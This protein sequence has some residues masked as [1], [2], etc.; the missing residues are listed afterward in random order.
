MA[1][2]C[3]AIGIQNPKIGVA[4][5]NPHCGEN[6]MFGK[7]EIE[8]EYALGHDTLLQQYHTIH[9]MLLKKLYLV[10]LAFFLEY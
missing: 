3:K 7:E 5:L 4:G 9:P 6:G 2:A 10:E 8:M 1:F